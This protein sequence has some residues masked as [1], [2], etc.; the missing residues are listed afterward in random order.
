[1]VTNLFLYCLSYIFSWNLF[2]AFACIYDFLGTKDFSNLH[3][4]YFD[5]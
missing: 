1:M 4:F 2:Y 3:Y 5:I